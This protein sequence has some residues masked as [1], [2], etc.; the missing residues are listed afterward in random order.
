M[1]FEELI[2]QTSACIASSA[3]R[4]RADGLPTKCQGKGRRPYSSNC[5]RD[6]QRRNIDNRYGRGAAVAHVQFHIVWAGQHSPRL[7]SGGDRC[8]DRMR[9]G[10]N[11]RNGV[12]KSILYE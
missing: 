11:G 9:G 10:V 4:I 7:V 12:G 3:I 5:V 6:G 2:E 8:Y 1:L